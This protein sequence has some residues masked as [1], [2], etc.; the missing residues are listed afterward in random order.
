[1]GLISEAYR[2]CQPMIV[3]TTQC[4]LY[5][6]FGEDVTT[7]FDNVGDI[8]F[9]ADWLQYPAEFH[10]GI[11]MIIHISQKPVYMRGF[12]TIYC[13]R[14]VFKK[15][16]HILMVISTGDERLYA[17]GYALWMITATQSYFFFPIFRTSLDFLR[18]I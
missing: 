13:T 14:D 10:K 5:C 17:G 1:M 4:F 16:S 12:S 18:F 2:N 3:A 11:Q 15:V 9:M 6:W 8:A 7:S